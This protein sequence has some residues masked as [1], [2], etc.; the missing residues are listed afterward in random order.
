MDILLNVVLYGCV[1]VVVIAGAFASYMQATTLFVGK[2]IAPQGMEA[3]LPRGFQD[4]ITPK[5]QE[6]FNTILPISYILI[7]VAGS[8]QAWY[9]GIAMLIVAFIGLAVAKKFFP[10]KVVFYLKIIIFY[11]TNK[12]ADYAK[13]GDKMRA[14]A[15]QEV[16][17]KLEIFY[18]QIKDH[19]LEVPSFAEIKAMSLGE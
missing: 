18:F 4:A 6:T 19:D 13:D 2:K 14:E 9:L 7:L 3:E 15:A 10:S 8:L 16:S 1:L 5:I 11:M 17:D 12:V